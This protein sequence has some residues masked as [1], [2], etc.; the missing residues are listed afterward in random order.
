MAVSVNTNGS[1]T[2]VIGTEHTLATITTAGIFQFVVDTS[3]LANGDAVELRIYLKPA[4][5]GTEQLTYYTAFGNAQGQP[6]KTSLMVPSPISWRAT[7]KQ[8]TG[9]GRV[10]PWAVWQM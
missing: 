1:Q 10:F 7:L 9:T 4:A 8:T 6:M 5:G 3:N 2:A